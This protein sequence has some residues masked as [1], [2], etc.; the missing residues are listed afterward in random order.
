MTDASSDIVRWSTLTLQGA[1]SDQFLSA[2]VGSSKQIDLAAKCRENA[3]RR[4]M[5]RRIREHKKRRDNTDV[6]LTEVLSSVTHAVEG[7]PSGAREYCNAPASS[8]SQRSQDS[9]DELQ[10][11]YKSA[12]SIRVGVPCPLRSLDCAVDSCIRLGAQRQD[13]DV[14]ASSR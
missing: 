8:L 3:L 9:D 1:E 13:L 12:S 7:Q 2:V 4:K 11:L 6:E 10:N 14:S 5:V